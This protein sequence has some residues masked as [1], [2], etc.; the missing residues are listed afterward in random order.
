MKKYDVFI[1]HASEDKNDIARPLAKALASYGV[2]VWF[3]EDEIKLGASLSRSIDKGLANSNFGLVILSNSFLKKNWPEYELR[4]LTA[5]EMAGR[6]VI[7][8]LWHRISHNRILKYSP[9]LADYRAVITKDKTIDE[10]AIEIIR[11]IRPNLF[12]K[13]HRRI[14]SLN[15]LKNSK[16]E[17]IFPEKIKLPPL[18]HKELPPQLIS[19][20][21]LLRVALWGVHSHSMKNWVD[22]F[23]GDSHPSTEVRWWEHVA[24]CYLE[25]AHIAKL[26]NREQHEAAFNLTFFLANGNEKEKLD[27]FWSTLPED[28]C[29]Q[30]E[31]ILQHSY[32]I[33]DIQEESIPE[34]IDMTEVE[35]Q[36]W[37][38]IVDVEDFEALDKEKL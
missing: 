10:I 2:Q 13:I 8:P 15:N 28:S 3:D 27:D 19:R 29:E 20:I 30:I 9:T 1:S 32:P 12:T 34:D 26:K 17:N 21:R 38:K 6:K 35:R 4:G 33:Y 22:S 16:V 25:Y 36:E 37:V 24:A 23:R 31:N 7:I 5:I 14:C 11:E 18:F